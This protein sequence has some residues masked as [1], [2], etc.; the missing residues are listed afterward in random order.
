MDAYFF[1]SRKRK[2]T[3][4]TKKGKYEDHD[5]PDKL[6]TIDS[7]MDVRTNKKTVR[8][9]FLFVLVLFCSFVYRCFYGFIL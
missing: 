5:D 4:P 7:V 2:R 9:L 3:G 6:F 8:A 1:Y